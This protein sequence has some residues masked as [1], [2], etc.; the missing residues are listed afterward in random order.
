MA[1]E[2]ENA[3]ACEA[4][5]G[6]I[7]QLREQVVRNY[8]GLQA[9]RKE[10]NETERIDSRNFELIARSSGNSALKRRY[11]ALALK[12]LEKQRT[13]ARHEKA[14]QALAKSVELHTLRSAYM[15]WMTAARMKARQHSKAVFA[16]AMLTAKDALSVQRCCVALMEAALKER[17]RKSFVNVLSQHASTCTSFLRQQYFRRWLE[18]RTMRRSTLMKRQMINSIL[19]GPKEAMIRKYWNALVAV[20]IRKSN[21]SKQLVMSTL[22]FRESARQQMARCFVLWVRFASEKLKE[23]RSEAAWRAINDASLF[24]AENKTIALKYYARW[25]CAIKAIRHRRAT[26]LL[27]ATNLEIRSWREAI[28]QTV[29]SEEEI[30]RGLEEGAL[31]LEARRRQLAEMQRTTRGAQRRVH[32]LKRDLA[33]LEY[34]EHLKPSAPLAERVD[35]VMLYFRAKGVGGVLDFPVVLDSRKAF[36]ANAAEA[37]RARTTVVPKGKK[38]PKVPLPPFEFALRQLKVRLW[39]VIKN[40]GHKPIDTDEAWDWGMQEEW[41]AALRGKEAAEVI[42]AL[43]QLIV[44]Y[45]GCTAARKVVSDPAMHEFLWNAYLL[46]G[47]VTAEAQKSALDYVKEPEAPPQGPDGEGGEA[48][49]D[50][51]NSP[52]PSAASRAGSPTTRRGGSASPP[53]GAASRATSPAAS[54]RGTATTVKRGVSPAPTARRASPPRPTAASKAPMPSPRPAGPSANAGKVLGHGTKPW[55]GFKIK[56]TKVGMRNSVTLENCVENGPAYAAGLR[57]GDELLRFGGVAVTDTRAFNAIVSRAASKPGMLVV[58]GVGRGRDMVDI[59][60]TVGAKE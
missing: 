28:A 35:A 5:E 27:D 13:R 60:I 4:E 18:F 22:L 6:R 43:K 51:G 52:R 31:A 15:Q 21:L 38:P 42:A 19:R 8:N 20:R 56:V 53:R 58:A 46:M 50:G 33:I 36:D 44:M 7:D 55:L 1:R 24:H 17:I 12:W 11:F 45:D 32:E 57:E 59:P 34:T 16:D 10:L 49:T 40:R 3:V 37:Q 9:Y 47:L 48:F 54:K 2:D 14:H 23:R 26:A 30:D 39:T 29:V 41:V 25:L